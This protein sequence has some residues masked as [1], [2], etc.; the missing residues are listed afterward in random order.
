[1]T[2]SDKLPKFSQKQSAD[3]S[4]GTWDSNVTGMTSNGCNVNEHKNIGKGWYPI[5]EGP[6]TLCLKKSSHL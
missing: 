6:S 1:M 4:N 3:C 2:P 5:H